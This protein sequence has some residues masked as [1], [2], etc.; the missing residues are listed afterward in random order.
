M[1]IVL[2]VALAVAVVALAVALSRARATQRHHRRQLEELPREIVGRRRAELEREL[3][4]V[5]RQLMIE[6]MNEAYVA[7]D[8]D[9]LVT[10][11]NER[12]TLMF[13]YTLEEALGS[14]VKE[15]IIPPEDHAD[16]DRL[17]GSYLRGKRRGKPL[18]LRVDRGAVRRD[19]SRFTV[20]L[21]AATLEHQGTV[22]LHT[23]MHDITDRKLS[24]E[25]AEAHAADLEILAEA[26][27]AL[28]RSTAP[29]EARAAV[30][31]AAGRLAGAAVALLLEPD[32]EGAAL[33]VTA[34][35]GADLVGIELP[36]RGRPSGAARV[37]EERRPRFV[38]DLADDPTVDQQMVERTGAATALFTPVLRDETALGVV[39]VAW[40]KRRAE[41]EARLVRMMG[42]IA[43]E[44]A[45]AIERAGKLDR[46]TR[47]ARTDDLTGL[48]NRRAWDR[49]LER[50]IARAR[51][52][53]SPLTVAMVDLDY[54]KAYNDRNGH[55]AGDRVLKQAAG[56]WRGVLRDTD[57]LARYGGEEFAIALP[58]CDGS[59][60]MKLVERLRAVTPDGQSCSAGV[61][62]WNGVENPDQLVGRADRALYEAKAAGRD[63]TV[64]A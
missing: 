28:A 6:V 48:P 27:G 1:L 36:L 56:A 46:L 34:A 24:E 12:A 44:A 2:T 13:G 22:S 43:A 14:S 63:R 39:V 3:S 9:G 26:T 33:R 58:S 50:E 11:W 37:F 47:I 35:T 32:A 10:D 45:V 19:G 8:A 57:L 5:R 15:L 62:A 59:S 25:Q 51:R 31:R 23:F 38:A 52:E 54:F 64:A 41:P 61:A 21:A 20:E 7:I 4:E 16:F 40:R 53:A 18:D 55:Q 30:C 17:I 60:A 42:L 49:E 29:Q